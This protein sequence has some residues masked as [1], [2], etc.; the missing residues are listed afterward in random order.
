VTESVK[1]ICKDK[2]VCIKGNSRIGENQGWKVLV[3][4]RVRVFG[5]AN[6]AVTVQYPYAG[7]VL[8]FSSPHFLLRVSHETRI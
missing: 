2:E 8:G 3:V 1:Q 4:I 5:A 6:P 7:G